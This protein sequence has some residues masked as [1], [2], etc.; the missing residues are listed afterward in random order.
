MVFAVCHLAAGTGQKL[1]FC[2]GLRAFACRTE[3]ALCPKF[4]EWT[5]SLAELNV[6]RRTPGE[7]V[8]S[9]HISRKSGELRGVLPNPPPS[10]P[11]VEKIHSLR[12]EWKPEVSLKDQKTEIG[13]QDGPRSGEG[14]G[15]RTVVRI[16]LLF[17]EFVFHQLTEDVSDRD[18]ALLNSGRVFSGNRDRYI[19]GL[20]EHSAIFSRE[21]NSF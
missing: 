1:R 12:I 13:G 6:L 2:N 18:V 15:R 21:A 16:E 10:V 3:T 17:K 8:Q 9:R 7:Q 11:P 14:R 5:I 4:L 20:G 19:N